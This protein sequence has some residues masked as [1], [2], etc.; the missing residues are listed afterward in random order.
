M[1]Q[2]KTDY[3]QVSYIA[4]PMLHFAYAAMGTLIVFL[5]YRLFIINL[6][7]VDRQNTAAEQKETTNQ[8]SPATADLKAEYGKYKL[9]LR[10]AAPGVFFALFGSFVVC[11]AIFKGVSLPTSPN[12]MA[13]TQSDGTSIKPIDTSCPPLKDENYE[14]NDTANRTH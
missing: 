12:Y 3:S 5:G 14:K 9:E 13:N 11:A 4:A 6:K 2:L 1:S 10:N 7:S 8:D